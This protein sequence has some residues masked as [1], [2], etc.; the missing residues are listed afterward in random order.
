MNDS[1][2]RDWLTEEA[3]RWDDAAADAYDT[4]GK[5]CLSLSFWLP[6]SAC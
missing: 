2:I 6:P 3:R 1:D 5:A 4:P